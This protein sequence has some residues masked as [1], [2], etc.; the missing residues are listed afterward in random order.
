MV[1]P[2]RVIAFAALLVF[3]C[4]QNNQAPAPAGRKSA[5]PQQMDHIV[6]GTGGMG[7]T[8]FPLGEAICKQVNKQRE[9]HGISCEAQP[10]RGTV[11]NLR[12]LRSGDIDI[13]IAQSDWQYHALKGTNL[14]KEDG[15]HQGL[16]SLFS[17]Y[18]DTAN[19][20]VRADSQIENVEDL[21]GKTVNA[22]APGSGTEAYWELVWKA[23]G[24]SKRQLAATSHIR[25]R[26]TATALCNKK[27]DAIFVVAPTPNL[28]TQLAIKMCGARL[29]PLSGNGINNL[30]NT[31]PYLR[32]VVVPA[33]TYPEISDDIETFG[34]SATVVT[35]E[36]T[37]DEAVY[38]L[39]KS[40][41]DNFDT[42]KKERLIF[43]NLKK[44]IMVSDALSAPLHRG[45]LKYYREAGLQ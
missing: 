42:F 29:L 41:F 45:A 20:I 44:E 9:S 39:V 17:V 37:S 1:F 23:F 22:G 11:A 38:R 13:G 6:I 3:G 2:R 33:G 40:V 19:L 34:L 27:I 16:R 24:K 18:P 15:P 14:F 43:S 36:E 30:V 8:Y 25:Y 31:R 7:G 26:D 5:A 10:T 12:A 32:H 35:T 4:T 21:V 28:V